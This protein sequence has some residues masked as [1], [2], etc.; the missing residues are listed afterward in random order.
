M[1]GQT[2]CSDTR[3]GVRTSPGSC[4]LDLG[5]SSTG[6]AEMGSSMETVMG[7]GC[8]GSRGFGKV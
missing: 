1:G 4:S 3:V 2:S 6:P 7:N 5:T 8:V